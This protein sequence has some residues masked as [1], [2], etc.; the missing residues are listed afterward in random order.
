MCVHLSVPIMH[1]ALQNNLYACDVLVG[2]LCTEAT[3]DPPLSYAHRL[4]PSPFQAPFVC[5][6]LRVL[7]VR[8]LKEL[9]REF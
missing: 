8:L 6:L 1:T 9:T 2:T 4:L 5:D 3:Q 7:A